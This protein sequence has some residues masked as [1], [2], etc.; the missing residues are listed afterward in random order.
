MAVRESCSQF[1]LHEWLPDAMA[2]PTSV[3]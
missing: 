1:P 3:S 2:G